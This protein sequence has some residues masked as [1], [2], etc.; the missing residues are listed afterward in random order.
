MKKILYLTF[1][2]EPD[3]CAGSFRNSPLVWELGQ[4]TKGRAE[5]DVITTFPNRYESF[6]MKASGKEVKDNVTVHRIQLPAHKSGMKDQIVSFKAYYTE[7]LKLTKGKKYDLVIASSSRLFTAYL[8]Y[9]IASKNNTPLYLD[10]RDIFYDTMEDVLKSKLIKTFALPVIKQIERKTFSYATHINLISEG[11]QPYFTPYD[12]ANYSYF[13]N[14]IDQIFIDNNASSNFEDKY[15]KKIVY[16]G[17][18]GEGQGLD[19]IIPEAAKL[20]GNHYEFTIIGDGGI[21]QRLIDKVNELKL[22]NVKFSN[23]IKRNELIK[24]YEECDYTFVHLNDYEAFKK[25]LPSKIFELACFPQPMIAGVG[26]YANSFVDEHVENKILFNPCDVDDF[27]TQLK[28]FEYKRFKRE[29]FINKFKRSTINKNMV[30]SM[31]EYL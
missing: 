15:P 25:V 27:V 13:T 28:N 11:F 20:L 2:F 22:T 12:K 18:L 24:V 5:I 31:L 23:P 16:A 8:G 17:N 26:G 19:K 29:M 3:L 14:G 9:K 6:K 1:Y 10:I 21:K 30:A 7:A 4:Q